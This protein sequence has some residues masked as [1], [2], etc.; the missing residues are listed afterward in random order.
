MGSV[1]L[2]AVSRWMA[3]SQSELR[4]QLWSQMA[5]YDRKNRNGDQDRTHRLNKSPVLEKSRLILDI[6]ARD[7]R[8]DLISESL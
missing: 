7:P 4:G 6:I 8:L 3:I 2:G 5:R 1:G